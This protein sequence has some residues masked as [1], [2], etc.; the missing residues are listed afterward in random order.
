MT[1]AE[2]STSLGSSRAMARC[3][4][5]ELGFTLVELL[6]TV[7]IAAILASFGTPALMGMIANQGVG[8]AANELAE[9]LRL[10]RSEAI[11]QGNPVSVCAARYPNNKSDASTNKLACDGASY[12]ASG[13]LVFSDMENNGSLDISTASTGST[14]RVIKTYTASSSVASITTA[15][16]KPYANFTP[17]GLSGKGA[18]TFTLRPKGSTTST[19]YDTASRTV[20]LSTSGRVSVKVGAVAC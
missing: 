20:C 17:N 18:L 15:S 13:W 7:S 11:K 14:D 12:W 5:P 3:N 4:R 10:A 2:I 9:V 6:V 16:N 19:Y 8:N 1:F